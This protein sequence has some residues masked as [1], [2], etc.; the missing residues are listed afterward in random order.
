MSSISERRRG[1]RFDKPVFVQAIRDFRTTLKE[2]GLKGTWR[3]YG[4]KLVVAGFCYYLVRD[5]TL[6]ILIPYYVA[7]QFVAVP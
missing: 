3:R 6:Y 2:S 7:R 1:R 4:W 5:I